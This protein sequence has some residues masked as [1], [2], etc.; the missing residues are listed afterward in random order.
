GI[1]VVFPLAAALALPSTNLPWRSLVVLGLG[2]AATIAMYE[3]FRA[4][5]PLSDVGTRELF[6]V[7]SIARTS[8]QAAILTGHLLAFGT[9]ALLASALGIDSRYPDAATV[10]VVAVVALAFLA[11]TW[12][13]RPAMRRRVLGLA[14]LTL[15]TVGSVGLGRATLVVLTK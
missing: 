5:L 2:A 10:G 15:A 14:L 9:I 3:I 11:A 13:A 4:Y 7:A 1:A 8:P 12:A 6:S